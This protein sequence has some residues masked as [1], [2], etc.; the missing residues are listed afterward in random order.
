MSNKDVVLQ[1]ASLK[2]AVK[3]AETPITGELV[4]RNLVAQLGID[5]LADV[6]LRGYGSPPTAALPH[7]PRPMHQTERAD[8]E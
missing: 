7:H 8:D 4:K 5:L 2:A 1:G 3:A 6:D